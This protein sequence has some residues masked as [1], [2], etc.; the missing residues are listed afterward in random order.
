MT[1]ELSPV[2]KDARDVRRNFIYSLAVHLSS[3]IFKFNFTKDDEPLSLLIPIEE[4]MKEKRKICEQN[5]EGDFAKAKYMTCLECLVKFIIYL[6]DRHH[7]KN[8][9]H[10]AQLTMIIKSKWEIPDD[11]WDEAKKKLRSFTTDNWIDE[12]PC[13]CIK[14]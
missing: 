3:W 4:Y 13:M 14:I 5:V 2:T 8:I 9:K 7:P 11:F 10:P 12:A 1:F 6:W